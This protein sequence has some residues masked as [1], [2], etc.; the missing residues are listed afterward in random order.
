MALAWVLRQPQVS[1]AITGATRLEQLEQNLRYAEV[2]LSEQHWLEVEAVIAGQSRA[3]RKRTSGG[4]R[5]PKRGPAGRSPR[6][7]GR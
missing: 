7:R 1:C 6:R 3:P 5:R 4:A 2:K